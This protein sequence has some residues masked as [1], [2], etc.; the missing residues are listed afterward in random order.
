MVEALPSV[1]DFQAI[2]EA[3]LPL[4]DVRAPIEFQRGSIPNATNLVL[5]ND[6]ERHQV[7]VCYKQSGQQQAIVLG[8]QMVQGAVREQRIADWA[9]FVKQH[10][11]AMLYCFRGGLRSRTSQQWLSEAGVTIPRIA[12][13]YK[14]FRQYLIDTLNQTAQALEQGALHSWVV[15]GRTGS[16]KT[17]LLAQLA[18]AVDLEAMAQHRGSSFGGRA[19]PQP[20]QIDFE[21]QLAYRLIALNRNAGRQRIFEDE[22]RNIGSVH[23]SADLFSAIKAGHRVMLEVPFD[24]RCQHILQEYVIEGQQEF[25]G[26]A[27]WITHM[28]S[29]FARIAKRLGGVGYAKVC[30]AFDQ[31]CQ[32]Q[33]QNHQLDAHLGWI[34]YLLRDYYDP[35]YDYQLKR[36]PQSIL[37]QGGPDELVAFFNQLKD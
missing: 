24:S 29:R 28:Q 14:A 25:G 20:S 11:S 31:A 26:L 37:M 27:P 15:A 9:A 30:Q 3:Q 36:Y 21:N 6:D 16:G 4:I 13:G 5:M 18:G 19:W 33:Q 12:G 23:L 2:A 17:A 22:G 1:D 10:P 34:L 35:M 8:H 7:G 32:Q